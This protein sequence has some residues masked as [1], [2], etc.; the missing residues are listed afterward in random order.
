MRALLSSR[1]GLEIQRHE[2]PISAGERHEYIVPHW[3]TAVP[4]CTTIVSLFELRRVKF[5]MH[6]L[7]SLDER[8]FY[9]HQWYG[10]LIISR[11]P[12]RSSRFDDVRTTLQTRG[13]ITPD[14]MANGNIR[15]R[16]PRLT[17]ILSLAQDTHRYA[18]MW[19]MYA[20]GNY[21][22][23]G[24]FRVFSSRRLVAWESLEINHIPLSDR[25]APSPLSP[26]APTSAS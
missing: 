2:V 19:A 20:H 15:V 25:S 17:R 3:Q 23:C 26:Q 22:I 4:C 11:L 10:K 1:L 21:C 13:T 7:C 9:P 12:M 14:S 6:V 16:K 18:N 5:S 8:H 24:N